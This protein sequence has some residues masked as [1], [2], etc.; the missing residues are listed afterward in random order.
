MKRAD[1]IL[2][3]NVVH[4]G[5]AAD[6]GVDLRQQRRRHLH[7]GNTSQIRGGCESGDIADDAATEG[8]ERRGTIRAGAQQSVVHARRRGKRL[9]FFS[10]RDQDCRLAPERPRERRAV[11]TPHSGRRHDDTAC[12][13][14]GKTIEQHV[15]LGQ[16]TGPDHDGI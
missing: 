4:A 1:Q 5:L 8:D 7:V 16:Q 15:D 3:D 11:Q 2:S 6:C 10:I 9:V 13:R 12:R 14:R